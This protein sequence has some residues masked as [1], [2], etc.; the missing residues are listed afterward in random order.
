[1]QTSSLGHEEQYWIDCAVDAGDISAVAWNAIVLWGDRKKIEELIEAKTAA[2]ARRG[3]RHSLRYTA[4]MVEDYGLDLTLAQPIDI[5]RSMMACAVIFARR[6]IRDHAE[7]I[8]DWNRTDSTTGGALVEHK[9]A[10]LID[11]NGLPTRRARRRIMAPKSIRRY[12]KLD[13]ESLPHLVDIAARLRRLPWPDSLSESQ[14]I[15]A[16]L[17]AQ[18]EEIR[19]KHERAVREAHARLFSE[20]TKPYRIVRQERRRS[21]RRIIKAATIAAAVLGAPTVS[22]FAR[23]ESVEMRGEKMILAV[24]PKSSLGV[25]GHGGCDLTIKSLDGAAL[26]KLCCYFESTPALDQLAAFALHMASGEEDAVLSAGNVYS[27]T[28]AGAEHPLIIGRKT[29][30]TISEIASGYERDSIFREAYF[31]LRG[32]HYEEAIL[33]RVWGRD[34]KRLRALWG[35]MASDDLGMVES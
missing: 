29:L 6:W 2:Y 34:A 9:R 21:R 24:K 7:I 5:Q 26:G 11:R 19:V 14:I 30:P 16:L 17:D 3:W 27:I 22:A 1:M 28:E 33:N 32:T 31:C 18:R 23:G 15:M 12:V 10:P 13:D 20:P 35:S 25:N 4:L 8:A